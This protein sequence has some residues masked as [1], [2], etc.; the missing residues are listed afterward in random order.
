MHRLFLYRCRRFGMCH[1][2]ERP[3]F[4]LSLAHTYTRNQYFPLSHCLSFVAHAFSFAI[5][6][7]IHTVYMLGPGVDEALV[8]LGMS[9]ACLLFYVLL[10]FTYINVDGFRKVTLIFFVI[11]IFQ[12]DYSMIFCFK[13]V[14][15]SLLDP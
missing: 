12:I 1:R 10:L 6:V 14:R 2:S 3:C 9:K 11:Y 8:E 7:L 13:F 5:S 4:A 15:E